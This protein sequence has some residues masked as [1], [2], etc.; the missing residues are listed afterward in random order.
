MQDAKSLNR[1]YETVAWGAF[2]IL[3]GVTNLFRGLPEGVGAVGIGLI[4]LGLNLARYLNKIPTSALTITLG[5]LA[6]VLGVADILRNVLNLQVEMPIFPLLLIAI[7]LIWLI[8]GV[9]R[10]TGR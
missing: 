6:L 1:R 9:T 10:G 7:G 8:R 4:F 5:V 3:L 2:F